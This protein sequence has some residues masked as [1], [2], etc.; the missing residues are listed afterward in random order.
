[1]AVGAGGKRGRA[2]QAGD[3][4]RQRDRRGCVRLCLNDCCF[5]PRDIVSSGARQV[6]VALLDL[7]D[8]GPPNTGRARAA[9]DR[10]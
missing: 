4:H 8:R 2:E 9:D 5:L 1:L 6:A 3:D 10:P 7:L